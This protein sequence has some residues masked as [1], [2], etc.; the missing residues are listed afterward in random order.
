MKEYSF[1][2]DVLPLKDKLYRLALR[3]TLQTDE[4]EDIVQ[5]TLIRVWEHRTEWPELQSIEAYSLTICRRLALDAAN[6]AG[7]G[8]VQLMEHDAQS[9]L[10]T[11]EA[12]DARERMALV[13][14]L[15]DSLPEVQRSIMELRDI[16]GY[17][18]QEIAEVLQLSDSQVKVYLH[19]ARTT[20]RQLVEKTERYGL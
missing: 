1:T 9:L 2:D 20:L 16:E 19:R 13:R 7:R 14:R 15:M 6:R 8:N 12:Q 3:I 4:A 18:Y 17:S 11:T 5:E 10:Q